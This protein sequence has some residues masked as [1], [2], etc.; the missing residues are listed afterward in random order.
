[1]VAIPSARPPC[2][3]SCWGFETRRIEL[4]S[5]EDQ[6]RVEPVWKPVAELGSRGVKR[7]VEGDAVGSGSTGKGFSRLGCHLLRVPSAV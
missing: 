5:D 4:H 3:K 7:F 6:L 2:D 1:V